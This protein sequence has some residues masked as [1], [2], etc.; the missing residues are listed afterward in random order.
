MGTE[1][2]R[3]VSL[4]QRKS[5]SQSSV[6]AGASGKAA[7]KKTGTRLIRQFLGQD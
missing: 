3:G 4:L 5:G 7:W 2:E 6:A 1:E